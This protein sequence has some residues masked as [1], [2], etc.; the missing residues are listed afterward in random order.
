MAREA[1]GKEW[2]K[3]NMRDYSDSIY[4]EFLKRMIEETKLNEEYCKKILR[5]FGITQDKRIRVK[6]SRKKGIEVTEFLKQFD[7]PHRV[8]EGVEKHLNGLVMEEKDFRQL[9]NI[10]ASKFKSAIESLEFGEYRVKA[11]GKWY[12]AQKSTIKDI[13]NTMDLY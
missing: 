10:P 11:N 12:W 1:K 7:I 2:I 3:T 13:N 6:K 4:P 5:T 8:L 9:L